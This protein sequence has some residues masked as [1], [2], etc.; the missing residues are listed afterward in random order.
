MD[1]YSGIGS[2]HTE[3]I[4][5]QLYT[6]SGLICQ[7]NVPILWQRLVLEELTEET[8]YFVSFR[9]H[10]KE[11]RQWAR[12]EAYLHVIGI[13]TAPMWNYWNIKR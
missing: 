11:L 1:V 7:S 3:L 2:S 12:R 10:H 13:N 4:P 6:E 5:I 8:Y 9:A